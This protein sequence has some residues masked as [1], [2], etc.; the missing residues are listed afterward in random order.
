M[1]TIGKSKGP[2]TLGRVPAAHLRFSSG[3]GFI[4]QFDPTFRSL[5][6]S[7]GN[8][9]IAY[10]ETDPAIRRLRQRLGRDITIARSSFRELFKKKLKEWKKAQFEAKRSIIRRLKADILAK[11]VKYTYVEV[12]L[13]PECLNDV[14]KEVA[15]LNTKRSS[16][17]GDV[18]RHRALQRP[19]DFQL[20]FNCGKYKLDKT[21]HRAQLG[22]G[23]KILRRHDTVPK[24]ATGR[25]WWY[26]PPFGGLED[27]WVVG[28]YRSYQRIR[29][30]T[31][32]EARKIR[33]N[34]EKSKFSL[35]LRDAGWIDWLDAHP[36]PDRFNDKSLFQAW[37]DIQRLE[38]QL[39]EAIRFQRCS[40]TK[41]VSSGVT[42]ET[43]LRVPLF[44]GND[45]ADG[46]LPA[47]NS[48]RQVGNKRFNWRCSQ[49]LVF[50]AFG[51]DWESKEI[52]RH[53]RR[54]GRYVLE[55][56]TLGQLVVDSGNWIDISD[57]LWRVRDGEW[58]TN[59]GSKAVTLQTFDNDYP[60]PQVIVDSGE[61]DRILTSCLRQ[62]NKIE[63]L[64]FGRESSDRLSRSIVELK[65]LPQTGAQASSFLAWLAGGLPLDTSIM[66]AISPLARTKV[67]AA[68]SARAACAAWLFWK[69]GVEPTAHDVNNLCNQAGNYLQ[70]MRAG[71]GAMYRS[72]D[73]INW[74]M[75]FK[76]KHR[77]H[78]E[79]VTDV[80][81][82][83][84]QRD[85]WIH[86]PCLP[87][88]SN[89]LHPWP[90]GFRQDAGLVALPE[91]TKVCTDSYASLV[92]TCANGTVIL[93]H[94]ITNQ[95]SGSDYAANVAWLDKQL[96]GILFPVCTSTTWK[97]LETNVF[98]RFS[99][100]DI[101]AAFGWKDSWL[102]ELFGV[103]RA[104]T[105]SWEVMPLSFIAD[106][107]LSTRE[108]M[109]AINLQ[110]FLKTEGLHLQPLDGVWLG[111]RFQFWNGVQAPRMYITE[112]HV[113]TYEGLVAQGIPGIP[114]SWR[115]RRSPLD[116]TSA[117]AAGYPGNEYSD[118]ELRA[119]G[120][121]WAGPKYDPEG[122]DE[123]WTVVGGDDTIEVHM[124][125]LSLKAVIDTQGQKPRVV[126]RGTTYQ[127]YKIDDG[128]RPLAF[129]PVSD[130]KLSVGKLTSL[131][132]LIGTLAAP[133][134]SLGG[135]RTRFSPV[136]RYR[137]GLHPMLRRNPS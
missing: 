34:L 49:Q 57:Q 53:V 35:I 89:S 36:R 16:L 21:F 61:R 111:H 23:G 100:D 5:D 37:S 3:L 1:K 106:W 41:V 82:V 91:Q 112:A 14:L 28:W 84:L 13:D 71:L 135:A 29:R 108:V 54:S 65:D 98:A 51:R 120:R 109:D 10:E 99:S 137:G 44:L 69:F 42:L 45:Y 114:E 113:G 73:A 130:I 7:D 74:D 20:L 58:W 68:K 50:P 60:S 43:S 115:D 48:A 88:T 75:T 96:Q 79:G 124:P 95:I 80:E 107:F 30:L 123:R 94:L 132:A 27:R 8:E 134:G 85:V 116:I 52:I 55:R 40:H 26:L 47:Y 32:R 6:P 66:P 24:D 104:L 128:L 101:K 39:S 33:R 62:A 38:H 76:M 90:A 119:L 12:N 15:V 25:I 19:S 87:I 92:G 9:C 105:T 93:S 129:M 125:I 64:V 11:R 70:H 81:P 31:A 103:H 118:E 22:P 56:S 2:A 117:M 131:A 97:T 86:L 46:R 67:L 63:G 102:S 136:A 4:P 83:S 72:V 133:R 17:F 18:L 121:F 110:A 59:T 126:G 122:P 78:E 77:W 127:R